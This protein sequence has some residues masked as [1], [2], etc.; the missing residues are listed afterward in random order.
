VQ[1]ELGE[2]TGEARVIGRVEERTLDAG[3]GHFQRVDGLDQVGQIERLRQGAGDVRTQVEGHAGAGI[4]ERL[5]QLGDVPHR[6]RVGALD[7]QPEHPARALA[8]EGQL[9]HR[10]LVRHK[11]RHNDTVEGI[12]VEVWVGRGQSRH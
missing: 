12:E 8:L 1:D 2:V 7:A 4:V 9:D 3:R 11:H 6:L 10:R 5:A